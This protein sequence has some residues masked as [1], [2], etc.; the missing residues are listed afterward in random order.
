MERRGFVTTLAAL[1]L[2]A[3]LDAQTLSIRE[4]DR[5]IAR[6]QPEVTG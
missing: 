1:Q 6:H 5:A 2:A 3:K 4:S